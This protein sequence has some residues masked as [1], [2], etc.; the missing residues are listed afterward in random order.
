MGV[1]SAA[2]H[3]VVVAPDDLEQIVSVL[4]LAGP[5]AEVEE[6]F[7]LGGGEL[8][9]FFVEVEGLIV[10]IKAKRAE[11]KDNG[12]GCRLISFERSPERG[13]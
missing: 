8:K 12:S 5:L 10:F 3:V 7:E 1:E 2:M 11:R 4:G 13:G 9:W 6:E